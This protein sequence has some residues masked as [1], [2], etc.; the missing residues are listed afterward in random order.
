MARVDYYVTNEGLAAALANPD[1]SLT[2][3]GVLHGRAHPMTVRSLHKRGLIAPDKRGGARTD[4]NALVSSGAVERVREVLLQSNPP[5]AP[6]VEAKPKGVT[7]TIKA[8]APQFS[9]TVEK[10]KGAIESFGAR[11][12]TFADIAG[13][14]TL[15][16]MNPGTLR[17]AIQVL[18]RAG[19][20][21]SSREAEAA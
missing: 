4:H 15:Q 9:P 16:G 19:L 1:V 7:Y 5:T 21:E 13:H 10:V 11:P 8:G 12:I 6:A 18:R 2:L 20:C 3:Q 17:W 14:E